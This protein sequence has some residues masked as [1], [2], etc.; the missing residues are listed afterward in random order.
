MNRVTL[1]ALLLASAVL[2]LGGCNLTYDREAVEFTADSTLTCSNPTR[3]LCG[4]GASQYCTDLQTSLADCGTCGS[5]CAGSCSGGICSLPLT[6]GVS[7]SGTIAT[8]TERD[9][10]EF[11]VPAGGLQVRFQTFDSTGVT[12][13]AIDPQIWIYDASMTQVGSSDDSGTGYSIGYCEDYSIDLPAGT[14]YVVVGGTIYSVPP[15]HYVLKTSTGPY[16]GSLV[17]LSCDLPP[18]TG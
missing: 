1:A 17:T 4:T 3:D 8:T 2:P 11:T 13:S 6:L 9:G 14:H 12:C 5:A 16:G 10:W 15:F 7:V 18:T